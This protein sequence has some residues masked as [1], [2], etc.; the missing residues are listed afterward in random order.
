MAAPARQASSVFEE[1]WKL[2]EELM[3]EGVMP[4][5]EETVTLD[6]E[7]TFSGVTTN[8]SFKVLSLCF[9]YE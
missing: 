1:D 9:T 7:L 3:D 6:C 8:I 5:A 2:L 4:G